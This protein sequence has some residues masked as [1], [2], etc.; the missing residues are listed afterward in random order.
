MLT[1]PFL[2]NRKLKPAASVYRPSMMARVAYDDEEAMDEPC[3]KPASVVGMKM[4]KVEG[5]S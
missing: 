2:L 5:R 3:G 1:K 4:R